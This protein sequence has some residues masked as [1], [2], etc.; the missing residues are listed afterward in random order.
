MIDV[1]GVGFEVVV[2]AIDAQA[3]TIV[4]SPVAQT[5]HGYCW[6]VEV[7]EY[8]ETSL[9]GFYAMGDVTGGPAFT[10]SSYDDYRILH[11][12]LVTL[13]KASTRDLIGPYT[14]FI[15]P[16]LGRAGMTESDARAQGGAIRVAKLPMTAE[17]LTTLFAMVDA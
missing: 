13:E 7:D 6:C 15:D 17:G 2:A 11:A 12:N 8:L 5:L 10:H 3:E 9:P 1:V 16:Q 14:V 4:V